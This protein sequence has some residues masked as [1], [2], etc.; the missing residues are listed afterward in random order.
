MG[1]QWAVAFILARRLPTHSLQHVGASDA[2]A[3]T[4]ILTMI[5]VMMTMIVVMMTMMTMTVTI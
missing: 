4:C 1:M 3:F 5:V 2:D